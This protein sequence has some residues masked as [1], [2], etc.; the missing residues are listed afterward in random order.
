MV[1]VPG[2]PSTGSTTVDWKGMTGKS[3]R[4]PL[5]GKTVAALDVSL[6]MEAISVTKCFVH[7]RACRSLVQAV[8]LQLVA[9]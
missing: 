1:R 5:A 9:E 4:H 2:Q 6:G 3:S 8:C 7:A